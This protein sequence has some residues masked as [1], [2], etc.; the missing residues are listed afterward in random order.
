MSKDIYCIT[1]YP[2]S[3]KSTATSYVQESDIPVVVMGDIVRE[4]AVTEGGI[5]LED[6][7][8]IGNWATQY[9]EAHGNNIFAHKTVD[10]V[11]GLDNST[12][13]ID[14]L[15]TSQE[16]DVFTDAFEDVTVIFIDAPQEERFERV[17]QRSRD[18][19]EAEFTFEEFKARDERET[20]WGLGELK[21]ISSVCIDNTQDI[22]YL[23][24]RLDEVLSLT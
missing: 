9:R 11:E 23:Y 20:K 10:R 4:L 17:K 22:D 3:G 2:A 16:L 12:I 14:G 8:A 19:Q 7:E 15:R 21:E 13:V 5:S 18:E 24:S 6:G 1:G